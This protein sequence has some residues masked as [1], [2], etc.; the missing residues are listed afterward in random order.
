MRKRIRQGRNDALPTEMPR[1][2]E[3]VI[4]RVEGRLRRTL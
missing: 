3:Q 4:L 2:E 1:G